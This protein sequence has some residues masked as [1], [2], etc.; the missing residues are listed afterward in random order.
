M[1]VLFIVTLSVLGA[2]ALCA[3][4]SIGSY[5][6]LGGKKIPDMPTAVVMGIMAIFS[7][8]AGV[9]MILTVLKRRL[10]LYSDAI[11]A[12]GL[13]SNK[14]LQREQI[15]GRRLFRNPK[16]FDIVLLIPKTEVQKRIEVW[17]G[18]KS[19]EVL[20]QWINSLPNLDSGTSGPF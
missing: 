17:T 12:H 10:V 15:A 7:L 4:I 3:W 2:G 11:E 8:T 1:I 6:G 13:F 19:D 14:R 16:G 18:L 5:F 20:Q 9:L